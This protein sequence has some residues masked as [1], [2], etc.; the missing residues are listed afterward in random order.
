MYCCLNCNDK[1]KN[2]VVSITTKVNP[3]LIDPSTMNNG[4]LID[5]PF[6]TGSG[7]V[8][9]NAGHIVTNY[10]VLKGGTSVDVRFLDGNSYSANLIGKDPYSD[11]V[12][13]A[14]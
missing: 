7:F 10:H 13:T 2:S 1:A 14:D 3:A 5:I 4:D 12:C 8:Y 6:S 9:D 11:L